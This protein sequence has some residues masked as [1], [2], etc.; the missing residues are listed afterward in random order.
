M[1][2]I[3]ELEKENELL[4]AALNRR[5]VYQLRHFNNRYETEDFYEDLVEREDH[6]LF[7]CRLICRSRT[8]GPSVNGI[9]SPFRCELL[10]GHDGEVHRSGNVSWVT[11]GSGQVVE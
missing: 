1:R 6:I 2:T 10:R 9:A 8:H 7:G 5:R 11:G 3:D 4:R